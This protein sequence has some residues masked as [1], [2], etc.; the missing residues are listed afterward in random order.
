M[1]TLLLGKKVG[2]TQVYDDKG[3]IVPVTVLQ[4]GPCT[5]MQV[6]TEH[7]DGYNALHLGFGEVKKSRQKDPQKGHAKKA[8]TDPKTF[9]REVRLENE[10]EQQLG[11][12]LKVDLFA[13]IKYVDVVGTTK[14]KG[15]AG[16]IKRHGFKGQLASHGVERK[17]RSPG[18]IG[19]VSGNTGRGIR[20]GKKMSGHMGCAR[21]TTKNHQ[22]IGV[23]VD[24][25]LLIVK[26][27]VAGSNNGYV[28]VSQAKTKK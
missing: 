13:G 16:F 18:S 5:V 9:V 12:Q 15:F 21:K 10:P 24:H 17:H 6:K 1:E 3:V 7:T 23:D 8:N 19:V 4:M 22:V 27:P 20:K 25:N 28:T 26:G 14:G 11:D 2:M